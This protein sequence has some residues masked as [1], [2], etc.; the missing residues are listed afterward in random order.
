MTTVA[1]IHPNTFKS[2]CPLAGRAF[3][4]CLET[5][6]KQRI[7]GCIKIT[8]NHLQKLKELKL[9]QP[10]NLSQRSN[11]QFFL[12]AFQGNFLN[13]ILMRPTFCEKVGKVTERSD[14]QIFQLS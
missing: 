7:Q 12:N 9:A 11:S 3:T 13:E 10:H 14:S 5:E 2:L 6:S 8:K 1:K 4:F